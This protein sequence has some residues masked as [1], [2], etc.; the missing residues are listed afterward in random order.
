MAYLVQACVLAEVFD[1]QAA[2]NSLYDEMFPDYL[3]ELLQPAR[4]PGDDARIIDSIRLNYNE[5]KNTSDSKETYL[6]RTVLGRVYVIYKLFS[7]L[8]ATQSETDRFVAQQCHSALVEQNHDQ[9]LQ[10]LTP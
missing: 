4:M 6:E 10:Q 5:Y 9:F 3:L 7:G 1:A 8:E 2:K